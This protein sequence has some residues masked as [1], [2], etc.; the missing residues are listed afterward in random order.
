M[1]S[2]DIWY[3]VTHYNNVLNVPYNN[4]LPYKYS[5]QQGQIYIVDSTSLMESFPAKFK[6]SFDKFNF[7]SL[8]LT[9]DDTHCILSNLFSYL[10]IQMY[11]HKNS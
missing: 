7:V 11:S 2:N 9:F 10:N 6:Q 4:K 1:V 8:E 5:Y 3:V